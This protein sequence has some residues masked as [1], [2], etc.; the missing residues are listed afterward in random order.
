MV[1][2]MFFSR[3]FR[4]CCC[5]AALMTPLHPLINQDKTR[6]AVSQRLLI[7][8][9]DDNAIKALAGKTHGR[10]HPLLLYLCYT[11][12][13]TCCAQLKDVDRIYAEYHKRGLD[14]A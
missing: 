10:E 3:G 13:Q 1:W 7:T 8:E 14:V 12:C 11:A 9:L 5:L 6:P 4:V 2:M